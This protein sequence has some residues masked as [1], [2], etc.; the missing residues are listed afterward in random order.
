MYIWANFV[1]NLSPFP[2][3]SPLFWI[4]SIDL[5]IWVSLNSLVT[6]KV[7]VPSFNI[8]PP[9][10]FISF[11]KD[12][13][14]ES[15]VNDEVSKNP[16]PSRI[17]PSTGT[18]SPSLTIIWSPIFN[19]SGLTL[20]TPLSS[21]LLANSALLSMTLAIVFFAFVVAN[22]STNSPTWYKA[23]TIH[24]SKKAGSKSDGTK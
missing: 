1:I 13:K 19:S 9:R 6:D 2:L 7:I 8:V 17:I 16:L 14:L 20:L 4:I 3:C 5:D 18:I 11:C 24:P 22:F 21:I 23:T 15:P 12:N 10:I